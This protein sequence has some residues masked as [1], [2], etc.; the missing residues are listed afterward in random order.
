MGGLDREVHVTL[1]G[2]EKDVA[3]HDVFRHYGGSAVAAIHCDGIAFAT[4]VGVELDL[5]NPVGFVG[6]STIGVSAVP[7]LKC[8][9]HLLWRRKGLLV[10][11]Q[12][13]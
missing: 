11:A 2:A 5:K 13:S 7:R 3:E 9:C 4:G 10:L 8:S 12:M 6:H 1:S